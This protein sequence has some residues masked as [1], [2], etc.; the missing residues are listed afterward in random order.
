[1]NDSMRSIQL[2]GLDDPIDAM[3]ATK[4]AVKRPTA[5]WL[6][7]IRR[8]C[9]FTIL[10]VAK[11]I[12]VSRQA[13]SQFEGREAAGTIS[14]ENLSRA[15]RALDCDLIYFL[16][17]RKEIAE[18]FAV[19]AARNDP[20]LSTLRASEHSM[21]LEGQGST[22]E[23]DSKNIGLAKQLYWLRQNLS[24]YELVS[25]N[26]GK[27]R[28]AG[29]SDALFG[30]IQSLALQAIA[31]TLCKIYEREDT[32][33]LN[34]IDGVINALL[35]SG[36]TDVQR[37]A[38]ERFARMHGMPRACE[39]PKEFLRGL[40]GAFLLGHADTFGALKRFRDKFVVHSEYG[41]EPEALPSF[42][43]FEALYQFAYD[44]YFLVSDAFLGIG[45][46]LMSM[47]VSSGFR[48]LL[49]QIGVKNPAPG[50]PLSPNERQ[51][52]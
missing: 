39:N 37:T 33:G 20:T 44:F 31:V 34:S 15:A 8:G 19:L 41:F 49:T 2:K 22:E 7:A 14:L 28:D 32:S 45:P 42:D 13:Y 12:G 6:K 29:A 23:V 35:N 50:F 30:H 9:G 40:L 3:R 1:M 17:P 5:G 46:A 27:I 21:V 47:H 10:S 11:R 16:L 36:Y 48:R 52:V 24:L 18:S 38:A 25:V 51:T 43:D 4:R 26:A